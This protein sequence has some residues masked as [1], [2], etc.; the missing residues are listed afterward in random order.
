[1][2]TRLDVSDHLGGR[3]LR[4]RSNSFSTSNSQG[5]ASCTACTALIDVVLATS[6][7]GEEQG[8]IG[9][10]LH[11]LREQEVEVMA[12]NADRDKD[13]NVTDLDKC[14]VTM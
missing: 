11:D 4:L 8:R 7:A 12:E 14:K 10:G 6:R 1:M 9:P 2:T 5:A 13:F 3:W